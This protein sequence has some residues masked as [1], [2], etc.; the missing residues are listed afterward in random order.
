[1]NQLIFDRSEHDLVSNRLFLANF[2]YDFQ[3]FAIILD[4]FF[5]R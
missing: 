5:V 2:V 4:R 3:W 1:M